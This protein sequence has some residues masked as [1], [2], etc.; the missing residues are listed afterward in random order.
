[1]EK[2]QWEEI[3]MTEDDGSVTV[4]KMLTL[5]GFPD[6]SNKE[7]GGLNENHYTMGN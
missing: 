5:A 3:Y 6:M 4:C 7:E 2:L 1:M